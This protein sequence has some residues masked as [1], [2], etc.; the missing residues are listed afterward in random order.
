M[1][2]FSYTRRGRPEKRPNVFIMVL[3]GLVVSAVPLGVAVLIL[4]GGE[5]EVGGGSRFGQVRDGMRVDGPAAYTWAV[6]LA[7]LSAYLHVRE[8]W[9][10]L[11]PARRWPVH[12]QTVALVLTVLGFVGTFLVLYPTPVLTLLAVIGAIFAFAVNIKREA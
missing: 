1:K 2:V 6:A 8:F 3:G 10:R 9:G 5:A 7:S 4:I 12:A 11:C